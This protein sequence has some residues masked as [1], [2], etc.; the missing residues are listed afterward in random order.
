M[1][2]T[3][4]S[5]EQ[6][7]SQF[8]AGIPSW[9]S[10]ALH[11]A[12]PSLV[13]LAVASVALSLLHGVAAWQLACVPLFLV[14]ANALEWHLH[15]DVL[16]R[17]VRFLSALYLRHIPGHHAIFVADDLA[18]RDRRELRLV[19][20]PGLAPPVIL[21]LATLPAA[22]LGALAGRNLGLLWLATASLYLVAHEAAHL[23][24]HLPAGP[25]DRLPGLAPLRRHHRHHHAGVLGARWNFNVTLP[26]WDAVQG[27][28]WRP[29]A[30]PLPTP[31]PRH[32]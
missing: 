2:V 29:G 31:I 21:A 17:R 19:L 25:L 16:H 9:Y 24:C 27:T 15:R 5:R 6:L 32:A 4:A 13:A 7:R 11:L 23:A 26:L 30:L 22:A 20:L 12:L 28:R 8:L 14:A 18:L 3:G 10:P 1:R